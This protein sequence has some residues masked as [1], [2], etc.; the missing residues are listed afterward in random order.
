ME[1]L[2]NALDVT[3]PILEKYRIGDLPPQSGG[4]DGQPRKRQ[5]TK[6]LSKEALELEEPM[7]FHMMMK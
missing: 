1:E 7:P 4:G 5:R 6:P 2:R 3:S